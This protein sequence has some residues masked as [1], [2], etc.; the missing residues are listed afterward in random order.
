MKRWILGL[1]VT[2]LVLAAAPVHAITVEDVIGLTR[3]EASDAIIISKIEADWRL[4]N[5]CPT[6]SAKT[7]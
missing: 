7:Q 1:L 4:C 2:G 3:A 5:L 6:V